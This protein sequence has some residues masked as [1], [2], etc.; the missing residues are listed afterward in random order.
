MRVVCWEK[1]CVN[2]LNADDLILVNHRIPLIRLFNR[3]H[4]GY[5]R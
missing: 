1:L 3:V 4:I 5:K 2:I